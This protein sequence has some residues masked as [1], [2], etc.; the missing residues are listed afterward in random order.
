M[1]EKD[2]GWE[3]EDERTK[4]DEIQPVPE[5]SPETATTGRYT[6]LAGFEA[7]AAREI[8]GAR[9]MLQGRDQV[10]AGLK[11]WFL[12]KR[13]HPDAADARVEEF[14]TWMNR[15]ENEELIQAVLKER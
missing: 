13:M 7:A 4:L 8:S 12:S 14:R 3:F 9:D 2:D 5:A 11:L 6:T 15:P 1:P 10:F